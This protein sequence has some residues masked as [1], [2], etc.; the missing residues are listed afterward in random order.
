MFSYN[1]YYTFFFLFNFLTNMTGYYQQNPFL[2]KVT[3][4]NVLILET[5][6]HS[7]SFTSSGILYPCCFHRDCN[8]F[9]VPY[10]HMT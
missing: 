3:S 6:K 10:T 8:V 9:S 2:N 1:F 5:N 7:I 4:G